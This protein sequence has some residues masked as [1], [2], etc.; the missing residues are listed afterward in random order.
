MYSRDCATILYFMYA[1]MMT[2]NPTPGSWIHV[3]CRDSTHL[4]PLSPYVY[5]AIYPCFCRMTFLANLIYFLLSEVVLHL[6]KTV[7][8][9]YEY[10]VNVRKN[11]CFLSS[12]EDGT[13]QMISLLRLRW[14]TFGKPRRERFVKQEILPLG[15]V[16]GLCANFISVLV[17]RGPWADFMVFIHG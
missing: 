12:C 16:P 15:L 1:V 14:I 9:W 8:L 6:Y 10:D 5:S 7:L 4:G 3:Y 13:L 11:M 17:L 2:E